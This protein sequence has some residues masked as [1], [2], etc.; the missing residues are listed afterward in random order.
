M[1]TLVRADAEIVKIEIS[2]YGDTDHIACQGTSRIICTHVGTGRDA[3]GWCTTCEYPADDAP[4]C[5]CDTPDECSC[6][7]P[8]VKPIPC[9]C[10]CVF[11]R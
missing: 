9:S 2:G 7:V 3:D 1:E 4:E 10:E 6:E 5:S 8:E 11:W